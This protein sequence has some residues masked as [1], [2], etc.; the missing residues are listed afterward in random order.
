MKLH[1]KPVKCKYQPQYFSVLN[2]IKMNLQSLMSVGTVQM[3]VPPRQ[4]ICLL[5]E[6]SSWTAQKLESLRTAQGCSWHITAAAPGPALFQ[7]AW[8]PMPRGVTETGSLSAGWVGRCMRTSLVWRWPCPLPN[9]GVFAHFQGSLGKAEK[10]LCKWIS[11]WNSFTTYLSLPFPQK[12]K[13]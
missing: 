2:I 3:P 10:L 5:L 13:R 7:H 9:P 1:G 4:S 11:Q 6:I 12:S 8:A